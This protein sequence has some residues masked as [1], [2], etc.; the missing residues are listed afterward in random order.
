MQVLV[1]SSV[2]IEY[3]RGGNKSDDLD[4]LIDENLIAVN[5][6][7]LTEIVPFL[8]LQNKRKLIRLMNS[9][10]KYEMK[11]D[12]SQIIEFQSKCLKKGINGVGV[13]DLLIAQNAIQNR[14]EIFTLDQHFS[15]MKNPLNLKLF[16]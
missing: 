13:P 1:D 3:F 7:I 12:W 6:L 5:D 11:I 4:I 8:R 10:F 15:L 9:I 16:K 2:W 14:C